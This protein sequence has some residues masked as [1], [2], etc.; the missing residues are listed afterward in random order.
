VE[1]LLGEGILSEEAGDEENAGFWNRLNRWKIKN[2]FKNVNPRG[3]RGL[4][5]AIKAH[6]LFPNHGIIFSNI[7]GQYYNL[8]SSYTWSKLV[9]N[10]QC[11]VGKAKAGD[12]CAQTAAHQS[13]N[14]RHDSAGAQ[15]GP[16]CC[17]AFHIIHLLILLFHRWRLLCRYC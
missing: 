13:A 6:H 11:H 3:L 1:R 12:A 2:G 5:S 10:A 16:A 17:I 8:L 15:N 14:R 9:Q 7:K 4:L